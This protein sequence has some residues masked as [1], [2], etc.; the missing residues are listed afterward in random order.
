MQGTMLP[1]SSESCIT[2]KLAPGAWA[3][4]PLVDVIDQVPVKACFLYGSYD[5]MT[6]GVADKLLEEGK[7]KQGSEVHTVPNAG[8]QMWFDNPKGCSDTIIEYEYG[9]F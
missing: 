8:H 2:M 9:T 3:R 6:R 1:K 4:H 5:W 7:L